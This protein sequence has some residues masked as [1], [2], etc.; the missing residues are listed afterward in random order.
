[1]IIMYGGKHCPK[2]AQIEAA[3]KGKNIEYTK[4][5]DEDEMI[6][7]GYTSMPVLDVDGQIMYFPEAFNKYVRGIG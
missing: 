6:A 3:L 4:I 2:C 7:K 1:M 5:M